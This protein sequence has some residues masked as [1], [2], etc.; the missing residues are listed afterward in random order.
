MALLTKGLLSKLI[1][2][3][4]FMFYTPPKFFSD[5]LVVFQS[6]AGKV[7]KQSGQGVNPDQ[8]VS[9]TS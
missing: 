2:L 5:L 8:L 4:I 6:L 3:N 7:D 9:Q 1:M